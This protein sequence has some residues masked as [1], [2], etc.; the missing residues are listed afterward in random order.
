MNPGDQILVL[1]RL[2]YVEEILI[3][4][5][6]PML[7]F[8]QNLGGQYKYRGYMIRFAHDIKRIVTILP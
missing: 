2:T 6:N 1:K 3:A 5:F 7:K 4:R 8:T